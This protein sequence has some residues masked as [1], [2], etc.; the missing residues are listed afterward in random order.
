MLKTLIKKDLQQILINF[1]ITIS[2]GKKGRKQQ[3]RSKGGV[4]GMFC[5][6]IFV[7]ISCGAAVA[8]IGHMLGESLIPLGLDWLYFAIIGMLGLVI[9]VFL[10]GFM[11]SAV[12]F[13]AKDNELLLSM[14]IPP[15][16][17]LV[18][19]TTELFVLSLVYTAVIFIPAYIMHYVVTGDFSIGGIVL[20]IIMILL[21]SLTVVA[22][23]AILGW[24]YTAIGKRVKNKSVF[25]VVLTVVLLGGYYYVNFNSQKYLNML[26]ANSLGIG[27]KIESS[28]LGY[29]IY[30]MGMAASGNPISII[31]TA[32]LTI[33]FFVLVYYVLVKTFIKVTTSS[34]KVA[35]RKYDKSKQEVVTVQTPR[36]ALLKKEFSRFVSSPTYM[37]NC[38]LGLL[39]FVAVAV[40]LIIKSATLNELID[41]LGY[42][43]LSPEIG[44][45][46]RTDFLPLAIFLICVLFSGICDMAAPSISLEGKNIW[47]LKSMPARAGDIFIAKENLQVYLTVP[48]VTL[49]CAVAVFVFNINWTSAIVAW[50]AAVVFVRLNAAVALMLD[51]KMAKLDWVNEAVPIKQSMQV[52]IVLFGS[53]IVALAFGALYY[54]VLRNVISA[55]NFMIVLIVVFTLVT[56]VVGKWL[57]TKGVEKFAAL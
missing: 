31:I 46:V 39:F 51:L 5:L 43:L 41:L 50:A 44:M 35:Q 7:F 15:T 34:E 26:V 30:Q 38:G 19:R 2:S 9:V 10:N 18:S 23:S 27:E 56:R 52:V 25:T 28:I 6:W 22:I 3:V 16:Y 24:L 32:A 49:F 12:L 21:N 4:I 33:V 48:A 54:F 29:P 45:K 36:K 1:G 53:W 20:C 17:I 57:D 11:A 37:L 42:E 47:I 55:S 40:M 14:P 13:K 8:G